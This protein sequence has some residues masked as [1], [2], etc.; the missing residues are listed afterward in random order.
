[1]G[2]LGQALIFGLAH[3]GADFVGPVIPVVLAIA[4]AGLIAGLIVRRSGSLWLP[5]VVHIAFDV[6]LYYA[7][8]CRVT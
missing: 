2:L 5:I 8:A 7:L 4:A 1:V 3:S 6:P